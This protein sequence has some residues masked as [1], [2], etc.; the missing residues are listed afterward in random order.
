[1]ITIEDE[2]NGPK[3]DAVWGCCSLI[4][5]SISGKECQDSYLSI[6]LL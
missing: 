6:Q 4:V 5:S 3:V 1:M 2:I